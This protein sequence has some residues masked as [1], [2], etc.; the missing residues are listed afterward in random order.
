MLLSGGN[1][2]EDPFTSYL[3]ILPLKFCIWHFHQFFPLLYTYVS[4]YPKGIQ[5]I[6]NIWFW[7]RG[8]VFC[9]VVGGVP[10][11]QCSLFK[12]IGF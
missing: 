8:E 12:M 3:I 5:E 7:G 9:V 1:S 10:D 2:G 6:W 11:F 4:L